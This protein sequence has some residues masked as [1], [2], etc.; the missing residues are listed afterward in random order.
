MTVSCRR[1]RRAA[2]S[3]HRREVIRTHASVSSP[4]AFY[5]RV[6]SVCI[7]LELI[8]MIRRITYKLIVISISID[9]AIH[10]SS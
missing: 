5:G 4:A 10:S 1:R 2:S 7:P 3:L 8:M 9:G 6:R